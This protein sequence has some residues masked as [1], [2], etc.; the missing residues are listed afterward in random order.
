[1]FLTRSY[2]QTFIPREE[3]E[4]KSWLRTIHHVVIMQPW[5]KVNE[6]NPML[7]G[8]TTLL[9]GRNENR[10]GRKK[11]G[12]KFRHENYYIWGKGQRNFTL[13]KR[14]TGKIYKSCGLHMAC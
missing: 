3:I 2:C 14:K 1:M 8:K 5:S 11:G 9:M 4:P 10:E 12:S 7:K 6:K 13:T